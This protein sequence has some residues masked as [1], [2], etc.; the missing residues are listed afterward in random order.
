MLVNPKGKPPASEK[1]ASA[2]LNPYVY[3]YIYIYIPMY[4][5]GEGDK[6]YELGGTD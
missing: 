6:G 3:I 1:K 2:V 4:V 5:W